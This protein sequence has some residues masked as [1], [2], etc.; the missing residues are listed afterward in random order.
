MAAPT[1][2]PTSRHL[3][4]LRVQRQQADVNCGI[5]QDN[6]MLH[7]MWATHRQ[8]VDATLLGLQCL[9]PET[10]QQPRQPPLESLPSN[11]FVLVHGNNS[12]PT[13]LDKLAAA[14]LSSFQPGDSLVL[15]SSG[16]AGHLTQRGIAFCGTILAIETLGMFLRYDVDSSDPRLFSIVGHSFGGLI[17]RYSLAFLQVIFSALCITPVSFS[18]LCTPHLGS[19]RPGGGVWKRVVQRAVHGILSMNK[20]YGQTGRDLLLEGEPNSVLEQMSQPDSAF[21]VALKQFRRRTLVG[22]V[23]RDHLVPHASACLTRAVPAIPLRPAKD[24][25][26]QWTLAHSGVDGDDAILTQCLRAFP[27]LDISEVEASHVRQFTSDNVEFDAHQRVAINSTL[28]DVAQLMPWRRLH[29]RVD[30]SNIHW[31]KVHDWPIGRNQPSD[32]RSDEFI[33]LFASMLVE[34]HKDQ[35]NA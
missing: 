27:R 28:L 4:H 33:A 32:S 29:I 20:L 2:S 11:I 16:N 31:K 7:A 17:A 8:H 1:D 14:L 25:S 21:V 19:R 15:Q 6:P 26:W 30:S 34:D 12:S 9:S 18:T 10:G 24:A 3:H 22:L 5:T 13:D 23:A 35:K